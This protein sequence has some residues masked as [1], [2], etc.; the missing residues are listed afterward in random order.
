MKLSS[1]LFNVSRLPRDS[2]GASRLSQNFAT[3]HRWNP[4]AFNFQF[5]NPTSPSSL[6]FRTRYCSL[7]NIRIVKIYSRAYRSALSGRESVLRSCTA[8]IVASRRGRVPADEERWGT[9]IETAR[10][11][12]SDKGASHLARAGPEPSLCLP[13]T[14]CVS[15]ASSTS[16]SWSSKRSR[17]PQPP[18]GAW[19]LGSPLFTPAL[20]VPLS[21]SLSHSFSL[22]LADCHPPLSLG[23]FVSLCFTHN[24]HMYVHVHARVKRHTHTHARTYIHTGMCRTRLHLLPHA[25]TCT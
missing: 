5:P 6:R 19:S 24:K 11:I 4:H 16:S 21:S 14:V 7:R 22:S 1:S 20:G 18:Q 9:P 15:R 10:T 17:S 8:S 3:V 2:I 25:V 12:E 23:I 13:T